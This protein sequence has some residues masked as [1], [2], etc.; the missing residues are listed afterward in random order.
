[1][2]FCARTRDIEVKV[3]PLFQTDLS[4]P[5][6]NCYVWSCSVEVINHGDR[7]I[8]IVARHWHAADEFGL[9]RDFGDSATVIGQPVL[10]PGQHFQYRS[11]GPL[12]TPSGVMFGHCLMQM[13]DGELL[14]IA[15]PGCSLDSP[16]AGHRM[17]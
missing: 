3:E 12:K 6:D 16:Y 13:E 2:L 4:R 5:Q 14:E 11:A 17:N 9:V 7:R 10:D 15:L 8:C 1:M